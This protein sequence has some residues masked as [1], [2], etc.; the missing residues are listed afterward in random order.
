MSSANL[1]SLDKGLDVMEMVGRMGNIRGA[2]VAKAF[3]WNR[4]QASRYLTKLAQR[5]WLKNVGTS[6]RPVYIVGHKPM[7]L[8]PEVRF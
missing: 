5:G 6:K 2:T 1:E 7:E 3:G 4:P 8:L